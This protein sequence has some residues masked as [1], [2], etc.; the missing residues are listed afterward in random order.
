MIS[1]RV[2]DT[3]KL[4]MSYVILLNLWWQKEK[5]AD[6]SHIRGS[7]VKW[8]LPLFLVSLSFRNSSKRL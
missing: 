5:Q 3:N 4:Q 6:V 2:D 1:S 8:D 7:N